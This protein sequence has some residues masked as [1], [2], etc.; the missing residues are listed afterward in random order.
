MRDMSMSEGLLPGLEKTFENYS[1]MPSLTYL[2][3]EFSYARLNKMVNRFARALTELGVKDNDRVMLYLPNCPQWIIAYLAILKIGGVVVPTSP[4]YTPYEIS[5]QI[6]NSGA[7]TIICQDTNYGYVFAVSQNTCLRNIIITNL[8]DLVPMYKRW[9]GKLFKIVPYGTIS[10]G[11]GIYF[12]RDLL[13]KYPPNPPKLEINPKEHL[14]TILYTG[15]TTAR[16]KGVP[17]THD[18]LMCLLTD[19]YGVVRSHILERNDVFIVVLPL[20]HLLGQAKFLMYLLLGIPTIV[21]PQPVIDAILEA[22]QKHKVTLFLGTPTLYRMI[23]END[24]LQSYD[25]SSLRFCWSGGDVL[26]EETFDSFRTLTNLPIYQIYGSTEAGLLACSPLDKEPSAKCLGGPIPSKGLMIVDTESLE[27]VLQGETGELLSK[28]PFMMDYWMNQ[29]ETA[30]SF[31]QKNGEKWY[32]TGDFLR[33]D[34]G[35]LYYVDRKS[36]LIK[37]KDYRVSA[38]EIEAVL[39]DH[40]AVVEACVVGVPDV[41]TGE[42]IKAII[43][44]KEDVR[45]V[46][47]TEMIKWCRERLAPYKIPHYI[48]FRD[49]LPKSKVGKLLR[50]EVRDDERRRIGKTEK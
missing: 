20:F 3:E 32:R 9:A 45:G 50:R 22:I 44:P 28:S 38:S 33:I 2:G 15:G 36:D 10:K 49:M 27:P 40:E 46:S 35:E 48:E 21:M 13:R 5:Y 42:R 39:Q 8:A 12:F 34:N 31:I 17:S 43:V 16:P 1:D 26:P 11:K 37:Y 25:L 47:G 41:R 6:N 4:I 29:E 7:E 18:T 30:Q 14:A 19:M 24:R 23:M